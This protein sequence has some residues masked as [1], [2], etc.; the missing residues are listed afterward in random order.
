MSDLAHFIDG[1]RVAGKSARYADVFDPATGAVAARVPLASR[2]EVREA[3]ESAR[4]A[5]TAWASVNPQRRAR[6]LIKFLELV[7]REQ[8]SL[9]TMLANEHG[10]TVADARGDIQRGLEVVE[11]SVGAPHLLKGGY[12]DAAGPGIDLYSMRQPLGVA[13]GITPLISRP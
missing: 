5:Q 11:F 2:A 4:Q 3:V 9:A 13:A 7:A 10:K 1:R 8:E 12:T 6:V